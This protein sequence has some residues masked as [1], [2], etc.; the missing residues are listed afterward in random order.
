MPRF[1]AMKSASSYHPPGLERR[2]IKLKSDAIA[3]H[4]ML[5]Y[6]ALHENARPNSSALE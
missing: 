2:G 6:P 1:V 4:K 5:G 3:G